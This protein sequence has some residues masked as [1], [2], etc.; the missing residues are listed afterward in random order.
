M[1]RSF[2]AHIAT[3]DL[4]PDLGICIAKTGG[5][6]HWSVWGR[7]LQLER[8]VTDVVEVTT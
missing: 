7:P 1:C 5:P 3:L 2:G 4:Q 8:C 6:A